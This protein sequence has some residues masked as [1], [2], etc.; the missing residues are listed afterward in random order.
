MRECE[1][2]KYGERGRKSKKECVCE[3]ERKRE[4]E[5]DI[6]INGQGM[7]TQTMA[8]GTNKPSRQTAAKK[9][10]TST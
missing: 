2:N 1:F 10:K 7:Q 6:T 5:R 3:I 9:Q 8:N 4:R